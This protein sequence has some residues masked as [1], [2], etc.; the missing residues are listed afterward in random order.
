MVETRALG[1]LVREHRRR[2]GLSQED[3]AHRSGLSVR[4]IRKIETSRTETPRPATLRLLAEALALTEPDHERLL[5]TAAEPSVTT[6]PPGVEELVE[7]AVALL[8]TA[9]AALDHPDDGM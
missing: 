1:A 8:S 2:L 3:L 4:G 7:A 5:R 9:L 6:P